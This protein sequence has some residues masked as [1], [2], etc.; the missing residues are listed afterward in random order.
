MHPSSRLIGHTRAKN[1]LAKVLLSE[2]SMPAWLFGGPFGVGK[3]TMARLFAGLQVDPMTR[4]EDVTSCTPRIDSPSG[5]LFAANTHPDIHIVRKEMA[6]E[7][8]IK[9]IRERKQ[10]SI[11][12]AVLRQQMIGGVAH[13]HT[14]NGPAYLKPC[15]GHAKVF[16]IDEAELLDGQAQSLLLKTL[17][18]PPPNTWFILVSTRPDRLHPTI[19][20]RCQRL[21][22]GLLDEVEMKEWTDSTELEADPEEVAWASGFAGG[23]SPGLLV[24]ALEEGLHEWNA[25]LSPMIEEL[26]AGGFPARMAGLMGELL[27]EFATAAEKA[28]S[29]TSKEA[30]GQRAMHLLVALIGSNLRERMCAEPEDPERF[31]HAIEVLA[32][33]E[34]RVRDNVNRKLALAGLASALNRALAPVGAAR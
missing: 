5:T 30:A 2:R 7:S 20:S 6:L 19:H 13:G 25:Q 34:S 28:N 9:E 21:N 15:H 29:L 33:A 18:E 23:G 3:F 1:T 24:E 4:E 27:E 10:R 32:E 14:F 22:F 26:V 31:A 17:E 16:I 11:P 12:M 8:P